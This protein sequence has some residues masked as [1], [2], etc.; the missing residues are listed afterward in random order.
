[1]WIDWAHLIDKPTKTTADIPRWPEEYCPARFIPH[2]C[3]FLAR[4]SPGLVSISS[5]HHA[6]LSTPP[7]PLVHLLAPEQVAIPLS[8]LE[9]KME[10]DQNKPARN[11]LLPLQQHVC[12][13]GTPQPVS[14]VSKH[15]LP[16]PRSESTLQSQTTANVDKDHRWSTRKS[17]EWGHNITPISQQRRGGVWELNQAT[18]KAWHI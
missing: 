5:S 8:A 10:K 2:C 11:A 4:N 17:K 14:Q 3:F 13:T 9:P 16:I 6:L 12:P 7:I 15:T 18:N 1:M